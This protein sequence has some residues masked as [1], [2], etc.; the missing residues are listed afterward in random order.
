MVSG[1]VCASQQCATSLALG[2]KA[3]VSKRVSSNGVRQ[4]TATTPVEADDR[5]SLPESTAFRTHSTGRPGNAAGPYSTGHPGSRH[6][7]AASKPR[8]KQ[9][10]MGRVATKFLPHRT[11]NPRGLVPEAM[12]TVARTGRPG[13]RNRRALEVGTTPTSAAWATPDRSPDQ[14]RLSVFSW[15]A[16]LRRR[17]ADISVAAAGPFHIVETEAQNK[18][19]ASTTAGAG[20]HVQHEYV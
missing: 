7:I 4:Y 15:D 12:T 14:G 2:A 16:G 10:T 18:R 8:W 19:S 20:H 6:V 9:W 11:M 3:S 1:G 5:T 17:E 13:E